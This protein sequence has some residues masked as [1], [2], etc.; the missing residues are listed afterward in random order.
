MKTLK[1]ITA[2]A[3][4]IGLAGLAS[5]APIVVRIGGSTAFRTATTNAEVALLNHGAGITQAYDSA[6]G[7]SWAKASQSVIH[8]YLADGT[9][10][11]LIQ[12]FW[13][14]AA[15]GPTDLCTGNTT[16]TWIPAAAN[17][18][19][20]A[21][22]LT[23]GASN[24][25]TTYLPESGAP[26]VA[27]AD[28]PITE[29]GPS[30]ASQG[31]TGRTIAAAIN[32]AS[33]ADAG[34]GGGPV[35]VVTF[36]WVLGS[37][38]GVLT[39]PFTNLTQNQAASLIKN[40]FLSVGVITGNPALN[41]DFVFLVGRNEDSG[42]RI[43]YLAES[44][45]SPLFGGNALQY[46]VQIDGAYPANNAYGSI[47]KGTAV[48]GLKIWP[49]SWPVFT[50][51]SLN[52][53]S[54]GHSGYNGGG[55]VAAALSTP[56]TSISSLTPNPVPAGFTVGSSKSYFVSC[57]GTSD[58]LKITSGNAI[59]GT[60]LTYNGVDFAGGA[61]VLNGSYSIWSYEHM[62]YLTT[63]TGSQVAIAGTPAQT[64]VDALADQVKSYAT[65]AALGNAGVPVSAMLA[66]KAST[67]GPIH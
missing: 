17:L 14:G 13:T 34:T 65:F 36:Q 48:T 21:V 66:S 43:N 41:G 62:Y 11:V 53:N 51:P 39:P 42:T 3:L 19:F 23:V 50:I 61:N 22:A 67:G 35:A 18:G 63:A 7:A 2:S 4:A 46:M 29:V 32:A 52:W 24:T 37:L 15:A 16:L 5:A 6:T 8:G 47:S 25:A 40:G 30:I 31:T 28:T 9:T 54:A 57:L 1:L 55:D 44:Q 60:P 27:M 45:N 38:D 20:P 49:K 10:E 33:L 56:N 58:A 64:V 12:N 59:N 26:S